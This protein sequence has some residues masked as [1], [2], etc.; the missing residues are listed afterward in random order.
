MTRHLPTAEEMIF[1]GMR[2]RAP[3]T[4]KIKAAAPRID[5]WEAVAEECPCFAS[6]ESHRVPING[7]VRVHVVAL[8][9]PVM[10][11]LGVRAATRYEP[12]PMAP[13]VH[14]VSGLWG[15][16]YTSWRISDAYSLAELCR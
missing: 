4:H 13:V 11:I 9:H 12:E 2:D 10:C 5:P 1:A 7:R 14:A 8:S 15:P 3:R 6:A 16:L